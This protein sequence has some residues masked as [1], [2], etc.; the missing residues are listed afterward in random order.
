MARKLRM[1]YKIL[2]MIYN[3]WLLKKERGRKKRRN[4]K[5]D[6]NCVWPT[7][8]KIFTIWP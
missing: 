2:I 6:R 1:I 8:S 7:K 5:C 3:D 4:R